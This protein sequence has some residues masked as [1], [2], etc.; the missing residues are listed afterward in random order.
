MVLT[1]FVALQDVRPDMGATQFITGTNTKETHDQFNDP[2]DGGRQ[3]INLLRTK[4]NA[5]GVMSAGDLC[6]MDSRL[7]HGGDAN[8]S[9]DRR[10]LLY[11]S[12]RKRGARTAPGT[13]LY[14]LKGK[15]SLDD[16]EAFAGEGEAVAPV[17][18]L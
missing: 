17:G 18:V 3:K 16:T 11:V 2:A 8:E 6:M 4:P 9:Q 5:K 13:L 14:E 12:F 10:V 1:S 7:V 15:Y